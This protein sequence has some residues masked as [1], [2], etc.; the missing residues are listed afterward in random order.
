[1]RHCTVGFWNVN[2][3]SYK[4]KNTEAYQFKH[5]AI[6]STDT[7]ILCLSETFLKGDD[8][9]DI[10]KYTWI[11]HNRT[12]INRKAVR[13]SGGVGVLLHDRIT[14]MFHYEILDKSHEG[15]LWI[16]LTPKMNNG[17]SLIICS[18][19]LPPVDT[20]RPVDAEQFFDELLCQFSKYQ[21]EGLVIIGGDFNARC[22]DLEEYIAGVDMVMNRQVI[23]TEYNRYGGAIL[24]FWHIS[25]MV[26]T[27]KSFKCPSCS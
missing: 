11:G 24:Y 25:I 7:D 22:S 5:Q 18:C 21:N 16:K 9:F 19:Y 26:V 15:I 23:D 20:S 17:V 27:L 10:D 6:Q 4:D 8:A 3:I 1:M 14:A 2:C 12:D 13:G